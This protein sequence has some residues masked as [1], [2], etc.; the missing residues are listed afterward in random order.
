MERNAKLKSNSRT[1]RKN[2]AK[3]ETL[4]GIISCVSIRC[5]S[6]D[7]ILLATIL[8]ISFTTKQEL[9]W[10][11]TAHSITHRMDYRVIGR[12]RII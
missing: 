3:E 9:W 8:W 1:L 10:S 6:A 11:L 7:N 5:N 2:A 12:G 4:L